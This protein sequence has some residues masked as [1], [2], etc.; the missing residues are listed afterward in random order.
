MGDAKKTRQTI[1][2]IDFP[3]FVLSNCK[4]VEEV[5]EKINKLHI[6][7]GKTVGEIGMV[8]PVHFA[9]ADA[10]GDE[11][12]VEFINKKTKIFKETV[13]VMIIMRMMMMMGMMMVM[14]VMVVVVVV[15]MMMVMM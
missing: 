15:I 4:N 13:G 3:S 1:T 12:V 11:I 5:E 7:G 2:V 8:A 10:N 9:I 14:M 6:T